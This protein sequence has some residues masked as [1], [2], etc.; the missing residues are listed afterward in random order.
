MVR[1]L[2]NKNK[3]CKIADSFDFPPKEIL[4]ELRTITWVNGRPPI[5]P[6][7]M[8]PR[9]CA[10]NSLLVGVTLLFGSSLSV[11]ST[12]SNVSKLATM[13]S[14]IAIFQT[15]ILVIA[16]KS[17]KVNWLKNSIKVFATGSLTT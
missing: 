4:A 13:A 12:Q 6:D 8:F 9:P 16:E 15:S 17:G 10:F 5:S 7:T 11:A 14:T 2:I 1:A 3:P